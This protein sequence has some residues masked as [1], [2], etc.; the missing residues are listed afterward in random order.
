MVI[1]LKAEI[2]SVGT[3]LLLGEII[4]TNAQYIAKKL[5]D[6]G[7]DVYHQSVVGDNMVR[8]CEAFEMAFKRSDL[9]ITTGGLGPTKD[10]MTKEAAAQFLNR[11]LV[12]HEESLKGI[13]EYFRKRDL[14]VNEGNRKQGYF[15]EGAIIL[16]NPN[17]TAP[18]CIVENNNKKLI[19]LPGPPREMIPLLE[20][21]VVPYLRKYQ[22]KVFAF[23]VLNICGIGEGDME[24]IIMDI[25]EKQTNPTVAPY[26][27]A[28]ALTLRIAASAV[29]QEEAEKLIVP[30]EKQI[31][32]R[33]GL[34]I[35]GEGD[36]TLEEVVSE[37][38]LQKKLTIATA[39]SCTGGLLSGRLINYP[40]ISSVFM[41]GAITYSNQSKI[42]LLGVKPDTLEEYG[43]VSE[44]VAKEM[45]EGI[46]RA[47]NTNIGLSVTGLAGPG[48]GSEDKPVG[49]IYI[50]LCINGVTKVKKVKLNGNRNRIRHLI[51]T[52]ALDFLRRE[53]LH[54]SF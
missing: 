41:E 31:R 23:K 32:E 33:L 12:P 19:L 18:A 13:E 28:H 10:D 8:V 34:N 6:L 30:V 36:A 35:Y 26:A 29:T 51:T 14:P 4:N 54:F 44:E 20:T 45:A 53:L 11:E 27:K 17:G 7:I 42:K 47:A 49:L 21:Q 5:A 43:A 2:I 3:E 48:G 24:E 25:V 16:P 46:Y 9:V 37:L 15:P 52:N 38:L 1:N 22:D 40:G 39:E 50:G